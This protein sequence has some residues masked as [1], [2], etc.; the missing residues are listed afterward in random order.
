[1]NLQLLCRVSLLIIQ[2]T[3]NVE[4]ALGLPVSLIGSTCRVFNMQNFSLYFEVLIS[5][6]YSNFFLETGKTCCKKKPQT[7]QIHCCEEKAMI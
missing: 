3:A 4:P 6:S 2:L 1:M 7:H 5:T